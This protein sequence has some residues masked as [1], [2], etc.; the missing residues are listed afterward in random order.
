[1]K[2]ID[3]IFKDQLSQPQNPPTEAWDFIQSALDVEKRR[4]PATYIWLP[5]SGIAAMFLI[6]VFIFKS[7]EDSSEKKHETKFVKQTQPQKSDTVETEEENTNEIIKENRGVDYISGMKDNVIA[8]TKNVFIPKDKTSDISE[9]NKELISQY[10]N[11]T[12]T[13]KEGNEKTTIVQQDK[14]GNKTENKYEQ[15]FPDKNN[16]SDLLTGR[17]KILQQPNGR[18]Q[19]GGD[20]FSVSAFFAPTQVNSFGGKS[21]LSNDFNNLN[22]QNSVNMS[23][24]ARVSY[25]INDKIKIRT[26]AGMLDIEQRTK[27]VPITVSVSGGRGGAMLY[28]LAPIPPAH[29]ISYSG[30]LR[31]GSIEPVSNLQADGAFAKSYLQGDIAQKIR[32]VEIPLE[33]EI[34]FAQL[35]K[36]GFN[37]TLGASS[38]VLTHNSI[39]AVTPE[40]S[41]KQDL[42]TATNLNDLSFSANAGVKIDYEVSK[43]MKLN[44]EPTFK[45]MIKPM[46]KVNDTKPYII[47]VSTGV[48]FSF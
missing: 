32:Y 8:W 15:I 2:N 19:S 21:L 10:K 26:G 16:E 34:N 36:L 13:N 44:I 11:E 48:T 24:G 17:N 42:G 4:K 30:D 5:V 20:K 22:I 40:S 29:N 37:A 38:Y 18:T 39:S 9:T 43:K 41:V 47:G 45:Y 25:A 14:N 35:N 31:V 7:N 6:G 1:M 23:Y 27:N 33:A 12:A 46:N 28:Q 3:K